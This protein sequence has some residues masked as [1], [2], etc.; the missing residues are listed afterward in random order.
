MPFYA[1]FRFGNWILLAMTIAG[2]ILPGILLKD[3]DN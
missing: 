2:F 1:L 3:N